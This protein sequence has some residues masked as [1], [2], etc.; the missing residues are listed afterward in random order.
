MG[1]GPRQVIPPCRQQ[2]LQQSMPKDSLYDGRSAVDVLGFRFVKFVGQQYSQAQG[3]RR[4][5]WLQLL[6]QRGGDERVMERDA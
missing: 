4:Q 3:G 6:H 2:I 1:S 5:M